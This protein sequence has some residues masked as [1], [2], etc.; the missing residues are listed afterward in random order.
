M[1]SQQHIIAIASINRATTTEEAVLNILKQYLILSVQSYNYFTGKE[2]EADRLSN[3]PRSHG[4]EVVVL[5]CEARPA[6]P[7]YP[8]PLVCTA[9]DPGNLTQTMSFKARFPTSLLPSLS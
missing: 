3:F 6:G 7:R 5:G 8:F 2:T 1:P 9:Q 4:C